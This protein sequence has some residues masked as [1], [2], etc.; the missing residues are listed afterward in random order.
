MAERK[1]LGGTAGDHDP[2]DFGPLTRR[3]AEN[4]ANF[5]IRQAESR[6]YEKLGRA[7]AAKILYLLGAACVAL[8]VYFLG[9]N[10]KDALIGAL[11][12]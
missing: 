5:A 9:G 11:L 12:K 8:G 7:V 6:Q 3:Q 1:Q 10:V 2:E 4:L